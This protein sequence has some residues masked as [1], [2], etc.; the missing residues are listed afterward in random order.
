MAVRIHGANCNFSPLDVAGERSFHKNGKLA[1][2]SRCEAAQSSDDD[3]QSRSDL[4]DATVP[5]SCMGIPAYL[6]IFFCEK[7]AS[8]IDEHKG[9]ETGCQCQAD[10]K[11]GPAPRK[12]RVGML[13]SYVM[14]F[15]YSR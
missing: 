1:R 12:E 8:K 3:L 13:A 9:Q 11:G 6:R 2:K 4:D 15:D 5:S 10:N 7:H 14:G